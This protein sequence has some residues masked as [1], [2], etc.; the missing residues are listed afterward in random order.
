MVGIDLNKWKKPKIP[1]MGGLAVVIGFYLGAVFLFLF[2]DIRADIYYISLLAIMGAA[3]VGIMDDLFDLRQR[4]KAVLPFVFALPLGIT[5]YQLATEGSSNGPQIFGTFI[6]GVDIGVLMVFAIPIGITCA[7]NA[8]NMLEG[9]N[10]LGAGLG[11]IMTVTMIIIS[12]INGTT[13]GLFLLVPLLGAL[14]AFLYF[15]KHPAKIFP[16]DTLTLFTGAI[17]ACAA[18]VS[19][20]KVAGALLFIPLIIEFFLLNPFL[21][22]L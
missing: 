1:E 7:A 18:I 3:V 16:G 8:S 6:L 15:N 5:I 19:Y 22:L 21:T 20:T 11:I 17:L 13:Q 14:I 4:I 2:I 10:G 12:I 9:F